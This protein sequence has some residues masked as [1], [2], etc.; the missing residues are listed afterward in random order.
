MEEKQRP[1]PRVLFSRALPSSMIICNVT[2]PSI[3]K[4]FHDGSEFELD[5]VQSSG[6]VWARLGG[7][8]SSQI[9]REAVFVLQALQFYL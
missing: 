1:M 4:S 8:S 9:L 3:I 7:S 2:I 6:R 5:V